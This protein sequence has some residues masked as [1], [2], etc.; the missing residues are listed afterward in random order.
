M[1]NHLVATEMTMKVAMMVARQPANCRKL[2]MDKTKQVSMEST[3]WQQHTR[4]GQV[5][6]MRILYTTGQGPTRLCLLSTCIRVVS[7]ASTRTHACQAN[8]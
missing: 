5:D 3:R 7:I 8:Q 6:A 2:C 1:A 4:G